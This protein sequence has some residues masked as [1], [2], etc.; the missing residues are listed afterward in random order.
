MSDLASTP[1]SLVLGILS[2]VLFVPALIVFA[3]GVFR[4]Y[5]LISAGQ[6]VERGTR[7]DRPVSRFGRMLAEVFGHTRMAKRPVFAVLHWLVMMGF[8][9]GIVVYFEAFIQVFNPAGGW[10]LLGSWSVYHLLEEILGVGTVVGILG[11]IG[12]RIFVGRAKRSSRF[13]YS[14]ATAARAIEAIVLVEGLGMVLV[15]AAKISAFGAEHIWPNPLTYWI[16]QLLPSSPALVSIFAFIK[17]VSGFAFFFLMG[18]NLTWGVGWHRF[19]AFFSIFFRSSN[20]GLGKLKPMVAD[21]EKVTLDSD[22]DSTGVGS[23]HD[24]SWKMLLDTTACTECGRCQDLCPAWNT[25]KPLSP[26]KVMMDL[27]DHA[28][29]NSAA[30]TDTNPAPEDHAGIDVLKLAGQGGV[31]DDDVLWSCTN[32]GACVDQCPVDIEHI[33]HIGDLR[34]FQVLA[35][36]DFP[37]ELAGMFT[38]IENK[39]NPWGRNNKER[40][41]WITAAKRDGIDIPVVGEDIDTLDDTEYLFWVGCAGAYDDAGKRTSRAVAELLHVAGVKFAV[42]SKGESCTGDPARRAGNEFLFQMQ[43]D[44]N[45]E[46]LNTLFEGHD[47]GRRKIITTC[48]HCFNTLRNEYPDFDG[49]YDVFH[50]TQLL[51]RLVRDKRLTP[52][53]RTADNRAPITY[54]DPCF[55]GRHNKVFDPPRELLGATGLELKEME[56]SGNEA[57][58]CGAGGARMFMEEKIGQRIS[59]FRSEQ[60]LA[61][62]AETVAVGCPFCNTMLTSGVKSLESSA[63]VTDVAVMLR[64]SVLIDGSLPTPQPKSQVVH[65][66]RIDLG[67]TPVR[68]SAAPAQPV[69]EHPTAE[70]PTTEQAG[71]APPSSNQA[72][73]A[74]PANISAPATPPAPTPTPAPAPPAPAAPA[75]PVTPPAPAAPSAPPVPPAPSAPAAPAAPAAPPAPATPPA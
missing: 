50:H 64:D 20:H 43:A 45:V 41:D 4:I 52:I 34:R 18:R 65:P 25:N 37:S 38:N 39:G 22:T 75:A 48:P 55:L 21:G 71:T 5:R 17:L 2:V 33:D 68:K 40:A 70:Q 66:T 19:T 30:L 3:I 61:T 1:L 7:T 58:C 59:E 54:H 24:A 36:A 35:E 32:C 11:F 23:L 56:K 44:K 12:Y 57:F 16:A 51:N 69:P 28:I 73:P 9:M 27:R 31:I 15:K 8:L 63:A 49:H 74:Q 62:G 6:P 14:N 60:A 10:P 42:L 53:P 47:P 29:A 26:K 46:K 72:A 13:F 67:L